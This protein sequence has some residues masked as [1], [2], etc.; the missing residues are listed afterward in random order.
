MINEILVNSGFTG[1][2]FEVGQLREIN[3]FDLR[4]TLIGSSHKMKISM[5]FNSFSEALEAH[6]T[7]S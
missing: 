1:R 4:N 6:G 2:L 5:R 3:D 7:L